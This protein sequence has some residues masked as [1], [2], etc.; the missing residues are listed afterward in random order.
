MVIKYYQWHDVLS[1]ATKQMGMWSVYVNNGLD[2]TISTT[3]KEIWD[4]IVAE[5]ES[6]FSKEQPA[7][8][9]AD[10]DF[11]KCYMNFWNGGLLF[12]EDKETAFRYYSIFEQ[13]LTDSSAVHASVFDPDG[14]GVTENT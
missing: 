14:N 4:F 2:D 1:L 13:P 11:H 10:S 8:P 12:F 5:I 7:N 3:D 6:K 9:Y